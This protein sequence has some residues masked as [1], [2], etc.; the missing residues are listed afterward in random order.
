[1]NDAG[2]C[3]NKTDDCS[4]ECHTGTFA[5]VNKRTKDHRK[6]T[7]DDTENAHQALL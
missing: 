6:G 3:Y 7:D 5:E 2:G 4:D 1:M